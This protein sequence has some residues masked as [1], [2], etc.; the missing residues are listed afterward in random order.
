MNK[1]KKLFDEIHPLF[2]RYE[3]KM[4]HLEQMPERGIRDVLD[5]NSWGYYQ[6]ITAF[7]KEKKPKQIVELGGAMGV[8]CVAMLSELQRDSHLY[9]ITLEEG[10]LEF[11][12]LTREYPNFTPVIGDD[13]DLAVWPKE[14]Q[15]E[16]TDMWFLDSLHTREQLTKELELYKPFFKKGAVVFFD[17]IKMPELYPV[18]LDV[19]WDKHDVSI[20]HQPHGFGM[21]VAT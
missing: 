1:A 7:I 11:S 4:E 10:G 15:L 6:F 13:L 14:C 3:P 16:D 18:W 17:D 20:L 21:A 5:K 19:K 12:F 2:L 9:S 8:A